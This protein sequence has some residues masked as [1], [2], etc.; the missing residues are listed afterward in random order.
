MRFP[1]DIEQPD[2]QLLPTNQ[3]T[4]GRDSANPAGMKPSLEEIYEET[5]E[6]VEAL[7]STTLKA[8]PTPYWGGVRGKAT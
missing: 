1:I 6:S 4:S 3:R 7:S 8:A 5:R 2:E